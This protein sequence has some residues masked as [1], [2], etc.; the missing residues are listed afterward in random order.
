MLSKKKVNL[1]FER[2]QNI[3]FEQKIV[4]QIFGVVSLQIDSAGSA[5][6]EIKID[7]LPKH[8][9]EAIRDYILEQKREITANNITEGEID[10]EAEEAIIEKAPDELILSLNIV[11]LIKVGVSQ[12]HIRTAFVIV[13]I[14]W[15]LMDNVE[16]IFKVNFVDL[17][18]DNLNFISDT[19]LAP[20]LF[21]LIV[22]FFITLVRTVLGNFNLRFYQSHE[23]FK[24]NSGLFYSTRS[25][26][27]KGK[28]TNHTM[29]NKSAS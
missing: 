8:Q 11:D 5:G 24:V 12:N 29:D 1:P 4:H 15:G 18:F 13:G 26:I 16:D 2:I 25:F 27:E 17:L 23:G 21:L 20:L 28:S 7:A 19:F 10:L 6:S 22:S 9:A 14:G 3:N